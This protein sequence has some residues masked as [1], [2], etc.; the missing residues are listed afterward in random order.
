MIWRKKTFITLISRQN[1]NKENLLAIL[2]LADKNIMVEKILFY[3]RNAFNDINLF[4][5]IDL[6]VSPTLDLSEI[7]LVFI[8]VFLFIYFYFSDIL[9]GHKFS[10]F[11]L[12]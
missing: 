7:R 9:R 4:Q 11:I 2:F 10:I 3:F 12:M 5:K 6:I 1:S 8:P